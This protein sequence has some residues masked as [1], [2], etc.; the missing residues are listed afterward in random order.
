MA[1][2]EAGCCVRCCSSLCSSIISLGIVILIYWLIF[3]PHQIRAYADSATL[4]RFNLSSSSSPSS[5]S[6]SLNVTISLRNP[7]RRVRIYYDQIS[8]A[9]FY[10]GAQ[11]GQPDSNFQPFFQ[12]TKSTE[13]IHPVF[14]GR[15]DDVSKEVVDLVGKEKSEGAYNLNVRLNAKVRHKLWFVKLRF[16]PKISC[17]LRFPLKN[18]GGFEV[19]F[20]SKCDVDY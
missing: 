20:G 18:N 3:Q 14:D 19:A 2:S 8:A 4:S 15:N 5:L 9:V 11:L 13:V 12:H 10:D 16:K 17:W 6:Y 1:R 7:N